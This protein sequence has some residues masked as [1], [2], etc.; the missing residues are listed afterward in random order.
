LLIA[1][2]SGFI[3]LLAAACPSEDIKETQLALVEKR[4]R[5]S[6]AAS[7]WEGAFLHFTTDR[8]G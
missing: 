6:S 1:D 8:R 7:A 5:T 2:S 4:K 3:Q